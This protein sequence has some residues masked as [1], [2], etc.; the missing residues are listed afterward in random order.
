MIEVDIE[1]KRVDIDWTEHQLVKDKNNG[2]LVLLVLK[3]N[4]GLVDFNCLDDDEFIGVLFMNNGY[5][6]EEGDLLVLKK[7]NFIYYSAT[8]TIGNNKKLY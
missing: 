2:S 1:P 4:P 5:N 6:L 8:V 7:D 3:A